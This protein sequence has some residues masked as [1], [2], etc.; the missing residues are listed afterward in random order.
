MTVCTNLISCPSLTISRSLGWELRGFLD[1]L[2]LDNLG[3]HG[4]LVELCGFKGLLCH[5]IA[6][7]VP[8]HALISTNPLEHLRRI[9]HNHGKTDGEEHHTTLEICC[10]EPHGALSRKEREREKAPL[11]VRA[12][13]IGD[14]SPNYAADPSAPTDVVHQCCSVGNYPPNETSSGPARASALQQ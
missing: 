3:V 6:K 8:Y 7:I 12:S 9:L 4:E 5:S 11:L 10:C 13:K 14:P 1:A 2:T